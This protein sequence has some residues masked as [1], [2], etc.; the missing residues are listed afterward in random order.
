[1]T[2]PENPNIPVAPLA[3]EAEITTNPVSIASKVNAEPISEEISTKP[4]GKNPMILVILSLVLV[5]IVGVGA[6]LFWYNSKTE[7]I[8]PTNGNNLPTIVPSVIPT[9]EET[10][11]KTYTGSTDFSFT[12]SDIAWTLTEKPMS[13][14]VPGLDGLQE[15]TQIKLTHRLE[16]YE[17]VI[18]YKPIDSDSDMTLYGGAAGDFVLRGST[19]FINEDLTKYALFWEKQDREMHYNRGTEFTRGET[20]FTIV[21]R[22]LNYE[23]FLNDGIVEQAD[24]ILTSFKL[25][26]QVT[27]TNSKTYT[28]PILEDFSFEYPATWQL[29]VT[30]AEDVVPTI[31]LK[32]NT[33]FLQKGSNTLAI[34]IQPVLLFGGEMECY[35]ENTLNYTHKENFVEIVDEELKLITYHSVNSLKDKTHDPQG[36]QT[37]LDVWTPNIEDD[38]LYEACG[39]LGPAKIEYTTNN[40]RATV[41]VKYFYPNEEGKLKVEDDVEDIVSSILE[42]STY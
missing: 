27:K 7:N 29:S 15:F 3:P 36:F 4:K 38:E 21:L 14:E 19:N 35:K 24:I 8:P 18:N 1:M 16:N 31:K 25:L 12:Y 23:D 11:M 32:A 28:S 20:A 9:E 39:S 6:Y 10:S 22:P 42:G 33:V 13:V 5:I 26:P 40:Y 34:E 41:T 37:F 30:E 17:L 2:T